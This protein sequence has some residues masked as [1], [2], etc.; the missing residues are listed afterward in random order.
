MNLK[1]RISGDLK[2]AMKSGDKLRLETLRTLRAVLLEKEIEKRGPGPGMTGED[3]IAALTGAAKKR[4]ESIE[5]FRN[6]GRPELAAQEEQELAIIQEYLP[7]Q[8][9]PEE[10]GQIVRGAIA[11]SGAAGP[12]DFGKVMPLV[13]KQVKGR[14]DGKAV[15]EMVKQSLGA[16]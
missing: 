2:A 4:K 8:L 13:M 10:I 11:E 9:S 3:E 6:G 1:D 16:R 15:Q 14:A 5:L 7:K 12:A